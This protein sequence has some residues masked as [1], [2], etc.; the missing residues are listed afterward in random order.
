M[1]GWFDRSLIPATLFDNNIEPSAW[2]DS[3]T[4]WPSSTVSVTAWKSPATAVEK[5]YEGGAASWAGVINVFASDDV[6]ATSS[7]AGGRQTTHL[8]ATNFGFTTSDIPSGATINGIEV[9]IE[10]SASAVSELNDHA[11]Y[12]VNG[13][14]DT[15][16]DHKGT[17]KATGT[18]WSTTDA[19]VAYGGAADTWSSGLTD[20]DIRGINFGATLRVNGITAGA[21]ASV[22]HIRI[23]IHYTPTTVSHLLSTNASFSFG[24]AAVLTRSRK[25]LTDS[26][27]A[28]ASSVNM[29]RARGVVTNSSY[30]LASNANLT[31]TRGIATNS[32][33]TFASSVLLGRVRVIAATGAYSLDSGANLTRSRGIITNSSYLLA[34]NVFMGRVR[35]ISQSGS[36][37]YASNVSMNRSRLMSTAASLQFASNGKLVQN[38]SLVTSGSFSFG[39]NANLA[40]TGVAPVNENSVYFMW[41]RDK[42][43]TDS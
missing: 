15:I 41:R 2:F 4:I 36:F 19:S 16:A 27:L 11:V 39:S 1:R 42:R 40:P 18:T 28:L 12:L 17:N 6:R 10:R 34:S 31:R 3:Q 14:S 22:D 25:V 9:E 35:S 43:L 8:R 30:L 20:S 13:T 23:R 7:V 33:Y 24:S 29:V 32:S 21:T 37:T 5:T 26:P 38:I